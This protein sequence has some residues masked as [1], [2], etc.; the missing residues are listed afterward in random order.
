MAALE[1]DAQQIQTLRQHAEEYK[2]YLL[3][4]EGTASAEEHRDHER[5]FKER[6]SS[7]KLETML[8]AEFKEIYRTLWASN[9]WGNK[10]W[11][12][13]NKLIAPNGLETIKQELKKLLY[14]PGQI[15]IRYDEFR[16]NV[17]GF[18]P[19]SVSEILHFIFPDKFCLWNEKPKSVLPFLGLNLLPDRFFKYQI[20]NGKEYVQCVNALG[21]VK[22]SL[23]GFDIKDFIDLDIFFWHIYDDVMPIEAGKRGRPAKA[24][25]SPKAVQISDHDGAEY[26]LL[27]LGRMLGYLPYVSA[28]DQGKVFNG[29]PLGNA[30][31]H[32][33][34]PPFAGDRDLNSAREIDVI[35]FGDDENPKYCFEVEHTMDIARSLNRLAQLQHIY[36]KFFIV[37]PQ[38]RMSKFDTEMQKFPYRRMHDRYRFI[39]YQQLASLVEVTSPFHELRVKL[40]GEQ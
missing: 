10:D 37:A 40:L 9:M 29:H 17:K 22:D 30:A 11:Y 38:E 28:R 20:T 21:T 1:L 13:E 15:D 24:E 39:S 26:Y 35:W 6:L 27:E 25:P 5:Y 7:A 32:K 4:P 8:P 18:G 34:I 36:A 2:S 3:T 16:K 12:I 19:S 31:V 23:K 33:E 14:G